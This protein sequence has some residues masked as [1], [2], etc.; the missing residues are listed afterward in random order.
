MLVEK[1]GFMWLYLPHCLLL[2]SALLALLSLVLMVSQ[3]KASK[4]PN[5]PRVF[6]IVK[7]PCNELASLNGR[8]LRCGNTWIHAHMI[9][10]RA[11]IS[12]GMSA[13][14]KTGLRI[15]NGPSGG[16]KLFVIPLWAAAVAASLVPTIVWWI[17]V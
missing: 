9:A 8:I 1:L 4:V 2:L 10:G 3:I 7:L 13:Q 17:S 15:L 5:S 11:K 16:S 12:D 6:G 14:S